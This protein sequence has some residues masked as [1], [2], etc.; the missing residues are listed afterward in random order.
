MQ[1]SGLPGVCPCGIA[2]DFSG[3]ARRLAGIVRGPAV[4]RS[5]PG[6]AA[7]TWPTSCAS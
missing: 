4:L 2:L 1:G 5:T 7:G 3:A 6:I